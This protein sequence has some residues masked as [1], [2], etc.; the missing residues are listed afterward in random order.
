VPAINSP[1]S[2]A[3]RT[4]RRESPST[5]VLVVVASP[6]RSRAQEFSLT[7]VTALFPWWHGVGRRSAGVVPLGA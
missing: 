6:A 3:T 7:L 5:R 1:I 2:S 4:A